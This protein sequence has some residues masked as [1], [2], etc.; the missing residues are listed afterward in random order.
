MNSVHLAI[1]ATTL[2]STGCTGT[3]PVKEPQAFAGVA[4][5]QAVDINTTKRW[6]TCTANHI[7]SV[8]AEGR[9]KHPT[10][11]NCI[12]VAGTTAWASAIARCGPKP[13][14]F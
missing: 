12:R 3:T 1:F 10:R 8:F 5:S 9:R 11:N 7:N 4:K 14:T 13:A 2:L 6:E